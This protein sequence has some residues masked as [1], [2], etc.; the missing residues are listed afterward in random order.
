MVP[1]QVRHLIDR[2]VRIAA[3]T[4]SVTA[5][6]IPNDVQLLDYVDPPLAHG[7]THTGVGFASMAKT[8]DEDGL[9][10]AAAVLN[11]GKKVAMLVGAGALNATEE[12][13]AI[14]DRLQAGCAKA[15]LGKAV[16]PDD[17]PWVP[18]ASACSAP[19]PP[20]T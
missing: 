7:T 4:R 14:A 12:V 1:G 10:Q 11:A 18:A 9:R 15:L 2:A 19:R 8:P 6:I 16:L 20:G 5:V 13:I 17:L 3:A